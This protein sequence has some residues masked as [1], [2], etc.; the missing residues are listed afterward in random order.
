MDFLVGV[1][2]ADESPP[3]TGTDLSKR[4]K[5]WAPTSEELDEYGQ[6]IAQLLTSFALEQVKH[7]GLEPRYATIYQHL[8]PATAMIE[9]CWKQ[10]TRKEDKIVAL[11]SQAGGIGIMQINQHVWRGFYNME[12]LQGD[13]AYNIQ[14]G[15]QILMRYFK[16]YG[17]Q[18]AKE[19]K[20]ADH[21]ARAA[22]AAYNAGPR[23]SRRF[24]KA[25]ASA[26]QKRVD[27][28]LWN[29]YQKV[30]AGGSADLSRC[31]IL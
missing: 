4:L 31:T 26:R 3:L 15:N 5:Y 8:V 22:Y 25:D 30:A 27:E 14:A 1:A 28:H 7:A 17:T 9:S 20:N 6:I 21:A 18:I 2:H 29:L 23:A 24:M 10:F 13:V 19:N 11:R 16:Q 12:R